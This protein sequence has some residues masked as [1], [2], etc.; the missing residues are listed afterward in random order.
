M[1]HPLVIVGYGTMGDY[2]RRKLE[3]IDG[4]EVVAIVDIDEEARRA[5]EADGF[6]AYATLPEA[7]AGHE[8]DFV[9]IATPNDSHHELAMT[10]L[11]AGKNVL[12]E[13]PAMVTSAELTEV[14]AEAARVGKLFM[15]HQN[16]RWDPDYLAMKAIYDQGVIGPVN[17]IETRVHG[18]RGIPADWR[19]KKVNGG[20]MLLDWGV[21]LVDRLLLMVD[22]P[23]VDL[24]ASLSYALGQEVDDGFK[25]YLTF[26]NGVTALVDVSTTSYLPLPLWVLQA[27]RGSAVIENWSTPGRVL[28]LGVEEEA[29]AQPIQAGAGMTKTMAPRVKDY[30]NSYKLDD[31]LESLPVPVVEADVCDFYR[32]ALA[33]VDGGAAPVITNAQVLRTMRLLEACVQSHEQREVVH[34]EPAVNEPSA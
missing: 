2:H 10:A 6:A 29:D 22:S 31:S 17:Y 34:F 21:H 13:K 9:L 14:I 24:Y 3:T 23:V 19:T 30:S 12:C 27:N 15:V 25:A 33:V 32:S 8:A 1:K 7:L 28:R 11:T 20:G 26:A 5:G 4:F 18:S 16:R